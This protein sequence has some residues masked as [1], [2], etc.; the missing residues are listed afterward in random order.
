MTKKNLRMRYLLKKCGHQELG[1]MEASRKTNRG[2][3]LYVAKSDAVLS[4]F[5]PLSKTQLNDSKLVS[6]YPLYV[7]ANVYCRLVYHNDKYHGS[8]VDNPRD[9]YRLYLNYEIQGGRHRYCKDGIVIMRMVVEGDYES[10][11]YIDYASP[12]SSSYATYSR[13]LAENCLKGKKNYAVYNGVVK[14]FEKVVAKMDIS[15]LP[16]KFSKEDVDHIVEHKKDDIS[17]LFT[18]KSFRDFVTVAYN[19]KCAITGTVIE[20]GGMN[21]LETAHIKPEAHGGPFLPCN[22]MPLC[23]DFHWAF[24]H[25]FLALTDDCHVIVSKKAPSELLMPYN[26]KL[27]FLPSEPFFRPSLEYIRYHRKH[28]FEHFE[29]IRALDKRGQ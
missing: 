28:V 4:F 24:D 7:H 22:G 26:D 25:G 23:R 1:S 8:L 11:L 6:F 29:T 15:H 5:P 12:D 27:I 17:R 18:E 19:H 3:Y 10:G 13:L 9:E 14:K 16:A 21:N 20:F 2:Q